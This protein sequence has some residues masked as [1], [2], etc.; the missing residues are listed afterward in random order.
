MIEIN[1]V[2]FVQKI[3]TWLQLGLGNIII[4]AV[5]R[6]TKRFGYYRYRLPVGTSLNGPFLSDEVAETGGCSGLNYFSHH[7]IEVSS[8]PDWF[9]NPW[10]GVRCADVGQHWSDISDFMPDLGVCRTKTHYD[11]LPAVVF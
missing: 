1:P 2:N 8:P 10:N 6:T 3:N 4:V 9:V 11:C 7:N 5:Y